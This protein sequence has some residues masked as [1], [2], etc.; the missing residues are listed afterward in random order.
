MSGVLSTLEGL[1]NIGFA[2]GILVGALDGLLLSV[3]GGFMDVNVPN[4]ALFLKG[5]VAGVPGA[6]CCCFTRN[7]GVLGNAAV[8]GVSRS[9]GKGRGGTALMVG[10]SLNKAPSR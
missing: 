1:W 5:R 4:G 10:C 9:L 2:E 7:S 6:L 3:I 8:L